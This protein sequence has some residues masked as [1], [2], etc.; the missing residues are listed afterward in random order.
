MNALYLFIEP[1]H[2]TDND[3]DDTSY[4]STI[5]PGMIY[6]AIYEIR[7]AHFRDIVQD[8]I[9]WI[10]I[11]TGSHSSKSGSFWSSKSPKAGGYKA[12]ARKSYRKK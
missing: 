5:F 1:F 9:T 10:N 3:T 7:L 4:S 12:R 6:D 8:T 11:K 2:T